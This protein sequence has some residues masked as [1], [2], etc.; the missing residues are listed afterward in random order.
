MKALAVLT[1]AL[2][3][4]AVIATFAMAY[5]AIFTHDG[6]LAGAAYLTLWVDFVLG[7]TSVALWYGATS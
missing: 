5:G 3:A 4:A 6:D 7:G 1:T 2:A